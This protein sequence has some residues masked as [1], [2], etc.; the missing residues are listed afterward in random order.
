MTIELFVRRLGA[1]LILG[2]VGLV[3]AAVLCWA[4][5]G[6]GGE[7]VHS[8]HVLVGWVLFLFGIIVTASGHGRTYRSGAPPVPG[9]GRVA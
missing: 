8:L 9:G 5:I 7:V 6:E 2:G 3:A 4:S 1:S